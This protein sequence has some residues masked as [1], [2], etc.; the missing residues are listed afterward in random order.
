MTQQEPRGPG[1][2]NPTYPTT[3]TRLEAGFR[4]QPSAVDSLFLQVA[5]KLLG[6]IENVLDPD[7]DQPL[8]AE[9]RLVADAT[10]LLVQFR[11]DRLGRAGRG[12]E[13]EIDRRQ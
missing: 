8:L 12:N 5:G 1:R 4:N 9:R 7:F 3:L 2:A 10:D 6:R 11:D 13:A